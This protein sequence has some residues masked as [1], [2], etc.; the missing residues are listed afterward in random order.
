MKILQTIYEWHNKD[1]D[2]TCGMYHVE[3][4]SGNKYYFLRNDNSVAT[5]NHF[6][7]KPANEC[8]SIIR[9]DVKQEFFKLLEGN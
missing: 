2:T 4:D 3:L 7:G 5:I 6:V 1:L 8:V 9:D